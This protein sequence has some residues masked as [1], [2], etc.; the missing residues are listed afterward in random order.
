MTL[1]EF[2]RGP[3]LAL[4]LAVFVLGTAW[5]LATILRRPRLPDLSPAREGAPSRLAGALHANVRAMWPRPAFRQATAAAVLNGYAFHVGLALV[6][7][8][9]APH[10]AFVTR[11][12]GLSW[13]ALPDPVMYLAA[14]V[15]IVALLTALAMRILDPVRRAI[16]N[17]DDSITWTL[18]FLPVLT[19]MAVASEPSTSILARDHVVYATPLAVH[20]LSLELLLLWFPFGK[21]MH[22]VLFAFSRGAS[23]IRLSHRGVGL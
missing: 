21:L 17:A 8:G 10:I 14:S 11:L 18:T 4:S 2:A 16:S 12:T 22:A 9:Y 13:P 6:V 20:L 5:R 19:G 3:A 1:L 15:T 23:G 7:F